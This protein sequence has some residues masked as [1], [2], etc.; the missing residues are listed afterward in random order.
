M[1]PAGRALIAAVAV[2]WPLPSGP[3][4]K[5][6]LANTSWPLK[7]LPRSS[8]MF[9][10]VPSPSSANSCRHNEMT[11]RTHS[12]HGDFCPHVRLLF[13]QILLF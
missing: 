2:P 11:S 3:S 10:E 6:E 13:P 8:W 4:V 9:P 12:T 5:S 1:V 7:M